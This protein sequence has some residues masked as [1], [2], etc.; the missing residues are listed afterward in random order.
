MSLLSPACFTQK[1]AN[2]IIGQSGLK[3]VFTKDSV[4]K[5]HRLMFDVSFV[6]VLLW[7]DSYFDYRMQYVLV[8]A[9][10]SAQIVWEST[11][12]HQNFVWLSK[13]VFSSFKSLKKKI[14]SALNQ[15]KNE[16]EILIISVRSGNYVFSK[17]SQHCRRSCAIIGRWNLTVGDQA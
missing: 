16:Q 8:V 14:I 2:I 9:E 13:L 11:R 17:I 4:E 15:I 7:L 5:Y 1:Q 12:T 3:K 6:F 10:M